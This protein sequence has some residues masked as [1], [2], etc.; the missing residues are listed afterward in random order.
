MLASIVLLVLLGKRGKAGS[1]ARFS[2][3]G[4]AL[5]IELLSVLVMVTGVFR[6]YN[7]AY[8]YITVLSDKY[9]MGAIVAC[10]AAGAFFMV[11]AACAAVLASKE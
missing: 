6:R 1:L 9:M 10:M 3:A 8:A 4:A 5:L 11:L 2:F 7:A